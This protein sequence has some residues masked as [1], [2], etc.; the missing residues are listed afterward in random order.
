MTAKPSVLFVCVHNAGKSQMA[1]GLTERLA[2][3]AIDVHSAGTAPGQAVNEL[4][5]Q[6][7][8]EVGADITAEQPK[9]ITPEIVHRVD[10]VV[11][12][13]RE[14]DVAPVGDTRFETW[15]IDEPSERGI[16]CMDRMRLV[17]D[18][19]ATRVHALVLELGVT[20]RPDTEPAAQARALKAAPTAATATS[21]A[22][23][24]NIAG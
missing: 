13:G 1:A 20:P 4:S 8:L 10:V 23:T 6:S 7:L 15:D 18:D 11:T 19:I 14:A 24:A 2:G 3:D 22:S 12:L 9:A 5:A 21:P 16:E 17:R